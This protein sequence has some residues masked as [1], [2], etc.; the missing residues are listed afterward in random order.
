MMGF[1][2]VYRFLLQTCKAGVGLI[3]VGGSL[4]AQYTD[5][6]NSNRPGNSNGAYAV[7]KGV[8]QFESGYLNQ[9][10]PASL[11]YAAQWNQALEVALRL[12]LVKEEL[13][14]MYEGVVETVSITRPNPVGIQYYPNMNLIP[15]EL[16]EVQPVFLAGTISTPSGWAGRHRLGLKY[17][18]YDHFKD[19]E[20]NKPNLYSW[21]ANNVFKLRNLIPSVALYA[22]ANY[23]PKSTQFYPGRIGFSPRIMAITQSRVTSK[24]VLT[25]NF[26]YDRI[27]TDD[28]ERSF[29]ISLSHNLRNPRWSVFAEGQGISSEFVSGLQLRGGAAFLVN[30]NFQAD[31]YI[32]ANPEEITNSMNF[33]GG[34]SYRLDFHKDQE[35]LKETTQPTFGRLSKSER[36]I[37]R[38]VSKRNKKR[39]KG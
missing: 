25:T 32:G 9:Q 19:P 31:F 27:G 35:I 14:L 13:E 38:K 18:L 12:G 20:R 26:A 28:P 17:L 4:Q 22:G 5:V 21:R 23:I 7:G 6:I 30:P 29:V 10:I 39:A 11:F 8:I 3:L 33:A 36:R 34:I 16:L 1:M 37:K 2:D 15:G 24:T